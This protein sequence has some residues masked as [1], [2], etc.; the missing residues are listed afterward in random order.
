MWLKIF[1]S[2][3]FVT[4]GRRHGG[5]V[6]STVDSQCERCG[7]HC[8]NR[9]KLHKSP[10]KKLQNALGSTL[11]FSNKSLWLFLVISCSLGY[12]GGFC[13]KEQIQWHV[14]QL[15]APLLHSNQS[16]Q[17]QMLV[18]V[19]E[20]RVVWQIFQRWEK[21]AMKGQKDWRIAQNKPINCKI[22]RCQ[23]RHL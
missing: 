20:C 4:D 16:W 17:L 15:A 5:A 10:L 12:H 3:E 7:F 8:S 21:S 1:I 6:V 22:P 18:R 23:D 14:A 11:T 2:L 9:V 19:S 13:K